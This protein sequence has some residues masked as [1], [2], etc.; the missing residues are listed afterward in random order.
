MLDKNLQATEK[1]RRHWRSY[2]T[3][4]SLRTTKYRQ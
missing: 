3:H 1:G 2:Q 4:R